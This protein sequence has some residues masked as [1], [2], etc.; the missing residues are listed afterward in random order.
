MI[1]RRK[2]GNLSQA[3]SVN[4]YIDDSGR[5]R[6]EHILSVSNGVLNFTLEEDRCLDIL[7]LFHRGTN[8]GF[9]SKNGLYSRKTD[10]ERAFPAGMLYTCGLDSVG[11]IAGHETHGRVH[12]IPAEIEHIEAGENIEITGVVRD[13]ALFGQNMELRRTIKTEY[14]SGRIQICDEITNRAYKPFD[15][16]LL[17]HVNIGWPVLD[18]GAEIEAKVDDTF[19]RTALAREN[20]RKWCLM[21]APDDLIDEMVYY[22]KT[23]DGRVEVRSIPSGKSVSIKFDKNVMPYFLEWKSRGSGDY[24][25]G[26]EPSTTRLDELFETKEIPAGQSVKFSLEIKIKDI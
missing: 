4:R 23:S 17:Y 20:I 8:I 6:G 1:D 9:M 11:G 19:G 24:A 13:S 26:I 7:Q 10:F 15:L 5:G 22:H 18:A 25:L 12:N 16:A 2:F 3:C 14:G 21:E